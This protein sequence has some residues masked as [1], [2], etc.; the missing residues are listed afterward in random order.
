MYSGCMIDSEIAQQQQIVRLQKQL[1]EARCLLVDSLIHMGVNN[2]HASDCA[3]AKFA[4]ANRYLPSRHPAWQ[5]APACNCIVSRIAEYL[6][7]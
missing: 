1:A 7:S 2:L 3:G 5:H 4:Q 6:K